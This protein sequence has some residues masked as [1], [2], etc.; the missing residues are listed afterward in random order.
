MAMNMQD[1]NNVLLPSGFSDLLP[2]DAEQEA[3]AISAL[4]GV[5]SKFGYNRIKPPLVEFE[6][7]LFAPGP[8]SAL[9]QETFRLMD[10]VSHR[11]MGVRSDIT[12]Q[13]ARIVSSRL[14]KEERPLRLMYAN[15]VLR[16]R[17]SQQRTARQFCQVGCEII[18]PQDNQADIEIC[19]LALEGLSALGIHS[20]TLDLN[21]PRL[22]DLVFE[23]FAVKPDE[24]AT[25]SKALCDRDIEAL[26]ACESDA[27]KTFMTFLEAS[28]VA[29]GAMKSL[30]ALNLDGEIGGAIRQLH[31]VYKGVTQAIDELEL[32]GVSL[33]IDVLERRGLE[34]H[35]GVAFGFFAQGA[36]GTLGRGGRY[37]I[38]SDEQ[39]SAESATGFTFYMDT[40]RSAMA[41]QERPEIVF[42]SPDES[43]GVIRTLQDE[44]WIVLR[45]TRHNK[46]PANCTHEYIEGKIEKL[47]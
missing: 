45:G 4:M 20:L 9:A 39:S 43:W 31:A 37:D 21:L 28:G 3:D 14:S 15:D 35:N 29:Q 24:R 38:T 5:F 19:V 27:A 16:T 2:P 46:Q 8:G 26:K 18:G 1:K 6:E 40:L 13:I 17:G 47:K 32:T 22:I 30:M 44:G 11:M 42:V 25:I 34:Y 12:A 7:S 41:I 33:T 36:R 23:E 10:P